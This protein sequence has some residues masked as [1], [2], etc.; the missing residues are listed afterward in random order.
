VEIDFKVMPLM[1][2]PALKRNIFDYKSS[3]PYNYCYKMSAE[4]LRY[5]DLHSDVIRPPFATREPDSFTTPEGSIVK[6]PDIGTRGERGVG[7]RVHTYGVSEA[8]MRAMG[9]KDYHFSVEDYFDLAGPAIKGSHKL[10]V[11]SVYGPWSDMPQKADKNAYIEK[12]VETYSQQFG[13]FLQRGEVAK[14]PGPSFALALE[15]GDSIT[16]LQDIQNLHRLGMRF[17]NPQYS[18]ANHMTT[19]E[20]LTP[21]GERAVGKMWDLGITIDLSHALPGVRDAVID[22]AEH[23]DAGHLLAYTHGGLTEDMENGAVKE[24]AVNRGLNNEQLKRMVRIGA[25]VGYTPAE[26]FFANPDA[27][28]RRIVETANLDGGDKLVALG[29]D[30]GGTPLDWVHGRS[31]PAAVEMLADVLLDVYKA[32]ESL[33][34]GVIRDNAPTWYAFPA[35]R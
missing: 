25:I 20:G 26:I 33:V 4:V 28:A 10:L 11:L 3:L 22:R 15:G 9:L 1:L 24:G 34:T 14:E 32:P 13:R 7:A 27:L 6:Y 31:V 18:G 2:E 30:S 35:T 16:G 12:V 8:D 23:R 21:F 19:A 5:S 29:T 17:I